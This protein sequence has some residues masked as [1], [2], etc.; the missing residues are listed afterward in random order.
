MLQVVDQ[1]VREIE[2][3]KVVHMRDTEVWSRFKSLTIVLI[4]TP[5]RSV[6]SSSCF[7]KIAISTATVR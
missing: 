2:G 5:Q 3:E 4:K 6:R 7:L 1:D